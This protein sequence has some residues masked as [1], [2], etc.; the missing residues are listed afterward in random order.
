MTRDSLTD[1]LQRADVVASVPA[2]GERDLAGGAR[3]ILWRRRRARRHLAVACCLIFGAAGLWWDRPFSAVDPHRGDRLV[4][5]DPDDAPVAE[6]RHRILD[7]EA[8]AAMRLAERLMDNERRRVRR[9]AY[10][11]Q[12]ATPDPIW[13]VLLETEATARLMVFRADELRNHPATIARATRAYRRTVE[14]FPNTHWAGV[15]RERLRQ[16]D[17]ENGQKSEATREN[18]HD[19]QNN[20]RDRRLA[21]AALESGGRRT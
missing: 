18:S 9:A 3:S 19:P 7:L 11:Q 21:A 5:Q 6:I 17:Q 10:R 2:L 14:L 13:R 1:L 4:Q 8:D 15:A 12:A 20:D 16:T